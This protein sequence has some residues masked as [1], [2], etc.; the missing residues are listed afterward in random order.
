MACLP[1]MVGRRP[2]PANVHNDRLIRHS[3]DTESGSCPM[4]IG[5]SGHSHYLAHEQST[6]LIWLAIGFIIAAMPVGA[7][8]DFYAAGGRADQRRTLWLR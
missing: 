3:V 2:K 4:S 7:M 6:M 5:H 1:Q 8:G